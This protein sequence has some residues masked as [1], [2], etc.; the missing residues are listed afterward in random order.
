ML[1]RGEVGGVPRKVCC[2]DGEEGHGDNIYGSWPA[3][4]LYSARKGR[5]SLLSLNVMG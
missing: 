3:G 4:Q 5:A 2:L 1:R